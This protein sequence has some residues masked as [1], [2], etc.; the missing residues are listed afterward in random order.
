MLFCIGSWAVSLETPGFAPSPHDEFA[1]IDTLVIG[2]LSVEMIRHS[3]G[4]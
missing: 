1:F 3:P 2:I 4:K